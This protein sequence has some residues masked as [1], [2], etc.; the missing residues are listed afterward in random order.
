[1]LVLLRI[2]EYWAEV[3]K[4]AVKAI[5]RRQRVFKLIYWCISTTNEL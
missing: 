1:M 5:K 2:G 4:D 3:G